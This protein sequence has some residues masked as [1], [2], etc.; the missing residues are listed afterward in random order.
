MTVQIIPVFKV[1]NLAKSKEFYTKRLGFT[2]NDIAA[3]CVAVQ[4]RCDLPSNGETRKSKRPLP[5]IC[6]RH[7]RVFYG[8]RDFIR[9]MEGTWEIVVKCKW[10]TYFS[11]Q[12]YGWKYN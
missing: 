4:K 10:P 5:S 3:D 7:W 11:N 2:A 8:K 12:R 1:T 6:R 9:G